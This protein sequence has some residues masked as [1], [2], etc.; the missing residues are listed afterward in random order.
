MSDPL[1]DEIQPVPRV[2]N[3]LFD[4]ARR[5]GATGIDLEPDEEGT[6]VVRLLLDDAL[7]GSGHEPI[8]SMLRRGVTGRLK[9]IAGL[10]KTGLELRHEGSFAL[11]SSDGERIEWHVLIEPFGGYEWVRLR[12]APS[13]LPAATFNDLPLSDDD[14]RAVKEALDVG[15]GLVLVTGSRDTGGQ[16]LLDACLHYASSPDRTILSIDE[17]PRA[18]IEGVQ[19]A[20]VESTIGDSIDELLAVA[21]RTDIDVIRVC[22]IRDVPTTKLA[23]EAA[24]EGR[25]VLATIPMM[26]APA[27]I[28]R[29][30]EAWIEP[31]VAASA[32]VLVIG[33][34]SARRTCPE[35][36]WRGAGDDADA[37]TDLAECSLCGGIGH[38]GRATAY[39]VVAVDEEIRRAIRGGEP[40]EIREAFEARG[41]SLRDAALKMVS[42]GLTTLAEAVEQTRGP[43]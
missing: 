13:S 9:S 6:L 11:A 17:E 41:G 30:F 7:I 3:A 20:L 1:D 14:V 37:D 8:P 26:D 28:P 24:L 2:L 10:D 12:V 5:L 40:A 4:E 27:A 19:S 23:I 33:V 42:E 18:P 31:A 25:L 22:E 38:H 34:V 21:L 36:G 15:K 43:S 16:A 29:L 32:V 35:C 39:Q